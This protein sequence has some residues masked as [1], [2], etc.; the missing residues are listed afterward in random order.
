MNI[1]ILGAGAIGST[2]AYCL[3]K[4]GHAVTLVARGARLHALQQA[5]GVS[6]RHLMTGKADHVPTAVAAALD[7]ETPWDLLL[8]S[9]Q[10]NQIDGVRDVVARSRARRVMFMFNTAGD[11][12]SLADAVGRDRF[13]WG[14]PAAL[15]T[16]EDQVLR[17]A[18]VPKALRYMQI[19]TIG[20]LPT[21]EPPDLAE[22]QRLFIEAGIPTT[23]CADMPAWLKTHA[24]FMTPLMSAGLGAG[25]NRALTWAE[26]RRA[27]RSMREGFALVRG[28]GAVLVPFQMR[29]LNHL[30]R[31]AVALSI[32]VA[33]RIGF[34]RKVLQGHV[35][36]ARGEIEAL[37]G[38]LRALG[39]ADASPTL[40]ELQEQ[41]RG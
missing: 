18:V 14:F 22:L 28:A 38:D 1:A 9:V 39:P 33:F 7:L 25:P 19:T 29:A 26:A 23:T 21:F 3:A 15:G 12:Q 30:P 36:H 11:I 31:F 2:F 4:A 8:V 6:V 27:G 5:G 13:Y 40:A 24:A 20:G 32:W 16:V 41:A 34:V 37:L 35:G 17:Y 10:R